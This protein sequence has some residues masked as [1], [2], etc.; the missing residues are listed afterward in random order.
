M[1]SIG[2]HVKIWLL[3]LEGCIVALLV[4]FIVVKAENI[5][6]V[7]FL[8]DRFYKVIK[9]EIEV[10]GQKLTFENLEPGGKRSWN[11]KITV[12]SH[13]HVSLHLQSGETVA[14]D[15]DTSRTGLTSKMRLS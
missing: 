10:C 8:N 2:E 7:A 13:Y 6:Q 1:R 12:D 9:G 4:T 5:G 15:V 3:A 14:K 11:F